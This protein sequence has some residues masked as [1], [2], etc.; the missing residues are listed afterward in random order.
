MQKFDSVKRTLLLLAL[1]CYPAWPPHAQSAKDI[2]H[3]SK[4]KAKVESLGP[5]TP[6]VIDLVNGS[7]LKGQI[8]DIATDAFSVTDR[9]TGIPTVVSF[10]EVKDVHRKPSAGKVVAMIAAGAGAGAGILYLTAFALSK[11]SACIGR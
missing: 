9:K 7:T 4:V 3:T 1:I 11:C 10:S 6:V 2:L 8:S 5:K